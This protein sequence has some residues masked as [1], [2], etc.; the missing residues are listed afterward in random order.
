METTSNAD[1]QSPDQTLG[2]STKGLSPQNNDAPENDTDDEAVVYAGLGVNNSPDI[3]NPGDE[4]ASD[5]LLYTDTATARH[6]TDELS[7]DEEPDEF[8]AEDLSDDDLSDDEI[9]EEITELEEEEEEGNE[10]Y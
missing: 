1:Q 8:T 4:E 9:D 3:L 7:N 6:A 10:R 5:T 2:N